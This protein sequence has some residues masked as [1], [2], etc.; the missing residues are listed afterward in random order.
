MRDKS[1]PDP[2]AEIEVEDDGAE[3]ELTL[4]EIGELLKSL[5]RPVIFYVF[6][7]DN[8]SIYS[9]IVNG[10]T[11]PQLGAVAMELDEWARGMMRANLAKQ[12]QAGVAQARVA[13]P[14]GVDLSRH[15]KQ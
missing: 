1:A 4:Q 12:Q 8:S 14:P 9:S 7:G 15:R 6:A 5:G 10:V 11:A 2:Q 13:V 3:R